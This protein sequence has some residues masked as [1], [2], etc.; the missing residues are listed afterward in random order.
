MPESRLLTLLTLLQTRSQWSGDELVSRL[1]VTPRTLRRDID[2][3]RDLG[4]PVDSMPGRGGGYRLGRGGRLPPLVLDDEEAIAVAIGLSTAAGGTVA[5]ISEASLRALVKLDHVLPWKLRH[6]VSALRDTTIPLH[7]TG[8]SV[9]GDELVTMARACEATEILR[10]DYVDGRGKESHRRVEPHRLVPTGRRWYLVARDVDR[11]DWRSF[12]VDRIT[13]PSSTG[14]TFVPQDPPDAAEFVSR[15]VGSAPYRYRARVLVH[16]PADVVRA[17]VPPTTGSVTPAG[18]DRAE[19]MTGADSLD[20]IAIHLGMLGQEFE[21][22]EPP[23]LADAVS[24][25]ADRLH[26]SATSS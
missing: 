18:A 9:G 3:L 10:F 14:Q 19:L 22:L 23:G 25:L 6:Q 1:E 26:R 21:I 16:A 4:Y 5:G 7:A 11:D 20:S 13:E 24:R 8:E 12:R 15:S 2:R 17:R